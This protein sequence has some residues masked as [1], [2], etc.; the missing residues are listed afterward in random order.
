MSERS[1]GNCT[2]VAERALE[3]GTDRPL[4]EIYDAA[5][6]DLDGVV[7]V[8]PAAV[9]HAPETLAM[10]RAGGMRLAFVTNNAARPP[11]KVAAHLREL[12]VPAE[13][14]EVATSAQAAARVVAGMVPAG[15]AV[16]IVGGEGLEQAIIGRGLR[17]VRAHDSDVAA[18]VQGYHPTVGWMQLAEGS[19]A[20]RSG[21]PWVASNTDL[22]IPTARGIAPG[23]GAL[24]QV[25]RST[26]GREPVVAGKPELAM[27]AESAER[28]GAQHPLIV[29]DRL[30]TDILG[31]NRAG[32]D[33]LLVLSGVTDAA[34]LLAA[35]PQL[36]PTFLA[37]DLRGLLRVHEPVHLTADGVSSGGWTAVVR[38]GRLALSGSGERS[39]G[40][41]V[42]CVAWWAAPGDDPTPALRRLDGVGG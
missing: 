21:V 30:D 39:E 19:F 11:E 35:T 28:V 29:G 42:A 33:S 3:R 24:V 22:T 32:A 14:D 25:I 26:T 36:R 20:V 10:A 8:G 9:P 17:P 34:A 27:H 40:L 7:Y 18:V 2:S 16:L 37:A 23:N 4:I 41:R 5:L 38:D 13:S 31:A 15:S 1:D 6:L 12:G